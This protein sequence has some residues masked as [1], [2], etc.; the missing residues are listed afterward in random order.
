MNKD[1]RHKERK[2]ICMAIT[3]LKIK[4]FCAVYFAG[5]YVSVKRIRNL[6][7][8]SEFKANM[9]YKSFC[10]KNKTNKRF[11]GSPL[12]F[13]QG[14]EMSALLA[15]HFTTLPWSAPSHPYWLNPNSVALLLQATAH[16]IPQIPLS[17]TCS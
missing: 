13:F 15:A 16:H 8:H 3:I 4:Y 2:R 9:G 17:H 5:M 14:A 11:H 6:R 12:P 7:L 1:I 10:L